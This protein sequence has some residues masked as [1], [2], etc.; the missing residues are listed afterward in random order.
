LQ[1]K[2]NNNKKKTHNNKQ[3]NKNK[4]KNENITNSG[5]KNYY[6]NL[7]FQNNVLTIQ[8]KVLLSR[9]TFS[10][11]DFQQY[12]S[13]SLILSKQFSFSQK[14]LNDLSFQYINFDRT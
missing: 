13:S 3:T 14:L 6:C 11:F 12:F 8:T 4:T 9:V 10:D 5:K 7:Q 2:T 1:K